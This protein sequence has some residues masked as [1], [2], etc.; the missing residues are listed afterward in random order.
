MMF[1]EVLNLLQLV[2]SCPRDRRPRMWPSPVPCSHRSEIGSHLLYLSPPQPL[3]SHEMKP[4][5]FDA[6]LHSA[7]CKSW[8]PQPCARRIGP[9]SQPPK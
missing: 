5:K 1:A 3:C 6:A 2:R 4:P 7:V 9:L 8:W